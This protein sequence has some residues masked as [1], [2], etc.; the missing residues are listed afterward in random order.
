MV[1][2]LVST[3][4]EAR[5]HDL[6]MFYS[7]WGDRMCRCA[8]Q[9][10]SGEWHTH[11]ER[12]WWCPV[13]LLATGGAGELHLLEEHGLLWAW[14]RFGL[15]WY[16]SGKECPWDTG[17]IPGSIRSSGEGN[18]NPL[19]YSCLETSMDRGAWQAT[20][21]GVTQSRTWLNQLSM[22]REFY[23]MLVGTLTVWRQTMK[24]THLSDP[25]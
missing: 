12:S 16:C 11:V 2:S 17:S 10:R 5:L 3:R 15:P 20:V 1:V 9:T 14:E 23:F 18:D 6:R 19:Q 21:H 22:Q 24:K 7:P 13:L 8:G 4:A 25:S